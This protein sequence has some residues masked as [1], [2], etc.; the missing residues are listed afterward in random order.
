MKNHKQ[1]ANIGADFIIASR[2]AR[3]EEIYEIANEIVKLQD[4]EIKYILG[5][6]AGFF[7]EVSQ[8]QQFYQLSE[9]ELRSI[10]ES[11]IIKENENES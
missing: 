8:S 11:H 1:L 5:M 2:F 3:N 6:F 7:N 10:A 4:D 9:N